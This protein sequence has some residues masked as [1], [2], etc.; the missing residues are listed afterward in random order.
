MKI[1]VYVS[2]KNA[3]LSGCAPGWQS[4]E[5]NEIPDT[6]RP[7]MADCIADRGQRPRNE[8]P[9]TVYLNRYTIDA[10][11]TPESVLAACERILAERQAVAARVAQRDAEE[12]AG[13]IADIEAWVTKP[14]IERL[15]WRGQSTSPVPYRWSINDL[16]IP[17]ELRQRAATALAEAN[18]LAAIRNTEKEAEKE[19]R[20]EAFQAESEAREGALRTWAL[21]HGSDLLRARIAE[22]FKWRSLA[23]TEYFALHTPDGFTTKSGADEVCERKYPDLSEIQPLRTFQA[24]LMPPLSHA[25]L[26]W[27][28]VEPVEDEDT[29]ES[30]PA[31]AWAALAVRITSPGGESTTIYRRF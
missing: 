30:T 1:A 19:A 12:L 24:A 10:A 5:I 20:R 8:E 7:L 13:C 29:G 25:Q 23:S 9:G 27:C 22:G 6:L 17:E 11:P 3:V 31:E 4:L 26:V 14:T 16:R 18:A 28:K 21:E 15:D 2:D